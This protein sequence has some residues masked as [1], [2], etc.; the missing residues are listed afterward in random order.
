MV[1]RFNRPLKVLVFNTNDIWR[2]RYE[3]SKQLQDLHIDVA[4]P[5]DTHLKLHERFFIRNYKFYRTDRYPGRRGGTVVA[6]KKRHPIQPCRLN[7]LISVEATEVLKG[8]KNDNLIE[9]R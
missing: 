4:L 7:P 2:Q 3:L 9:T 8:S 5:S 6:V 1:T